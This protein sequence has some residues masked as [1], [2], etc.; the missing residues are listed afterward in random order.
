[1]K[2]SEIIKETPRCSASPQPQTSLAKESEMET[3]KEI[4][5]KDYKMPDYYFNKVGKYAIDHRII[6]I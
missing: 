4:F 3:P 1:M 6:F 2:V 5:L